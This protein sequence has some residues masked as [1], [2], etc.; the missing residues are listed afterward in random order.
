MITIRYQTDDNQLFD[1]TEAA[2][3]HVEEEELEQL[4]TTT[5][6]QRAGRGEAPLFTVDRIADLF[7]KSGN[8]RA[9]ADLVAKGADVQ[10]KRALVP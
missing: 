1:S 7:G 3:L 6:A 4:V 2:E 10:A 9:L 8:A 5:L